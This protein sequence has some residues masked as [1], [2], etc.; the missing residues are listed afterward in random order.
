MRQWTITSTAK[1]VESLIK[2][3]ENLKKEIEIRISDWEVWQIQ[4]AQSEQFRQ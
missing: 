3:I 1:E 4:Y 2:E